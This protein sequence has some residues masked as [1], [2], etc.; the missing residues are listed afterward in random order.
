MAFIL[1]KSGVWLLQRVGFFPLKTIFAHSEIIIWRFEKN[2]L[3]APWDLKS[4]SWKALKKKKIPLCMGDI[5]TSPNFVIS[6]EQLLAKKLVMLHK[7]DRSVCVNLHNLIDCLGNVI[8]SCKNP[9]FTKQKKLKRNVSSLCSSNITGTA[10]S[11]SWQRQA[12][13][14]SS[15]P[16]CF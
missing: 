10:V 5:D 16:G 11:A 8:F 13:I 12:Y 4:F 9:L 2:C 1:R 3:D 15:S 7:R 6:C 14:I